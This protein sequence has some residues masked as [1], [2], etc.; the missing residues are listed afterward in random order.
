MRRIPGNLK[1]GS[2]HSR[3]GFMVS[4]EA[5]LKFVPVD[6]RI[7]SNK[8]TRKL[9]R[10]L[11]DGRRAHHY[12][13]D[14]LFWFGVN[15]PTGAAE[16]MDAE[17]VAEICGWD[18]DPG[19][20]LAALVSA[21]W[22]AFDGGV[23]T[24]PSWQE[25]GGRAVKAREDTR[26]RVAKSRAKKRDTKQTDAGGNG[27][28]TVTP[29][30]H[31]RSCN[32]TKV[33]VE[34][35]VEEK[36]P[37]KHSAREARPTGPEWDQVKPEDHQGH[38]S[39]EELYGE[40]RIAVIALNR[41]EGAPLCWP[42]LVAQKFHS[43]FT[44]AEPHCFVGE[45]LEEA[46]G[47]TQQ[48]ATGSPISYLVGALHGLRS[49]IAQNRA[50]D[51]L[52]SKKDAELAAFY[53]RDCGLDTTVYEPTPLSQDKLA[54]KGRALLRGLDIDAID[55]GDLTFTDDGEPVWLNPEA[56]PEDEEV[57]F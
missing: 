54:Q 20:L 38:V 9:A 51:A 5:A 6:P 50:R 1:S 56:K 19:C 28:V 53:G 18:G 41:L 55:R 7:S 4:N 26:Q 2:D 40:Q 39:A 31:V 10:L 3:K 17:E 48:G 57:G 13:L 30:N 43:K 23:L 46:I 36:E 25:H 8:K 21:G 52:P 15:E 11:G 42:P 27:N 35:E 34:V 49:E 29:P 12:V 32:A 22:V 16:D 33:E 44:V 24:V 45:I 14:L 37:V 47:K